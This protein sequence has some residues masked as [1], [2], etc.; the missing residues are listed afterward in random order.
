MH[1]HRTV[2]K[3]A[4]GY[5]QDGVSRKVN[6]EKVRVRSANNAGGLKISPP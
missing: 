6:I 2:V 3:G 1:D 5:R 4:C